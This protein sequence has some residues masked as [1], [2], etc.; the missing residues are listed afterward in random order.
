M[1]T[2]PYF[3]MIYH[4]QNAQH[5]HK[6]KTNH[7]HTHKRLRMADLSAVAATAVVATTKSAAAVNFPATNLLAWRNVECH[8]PDSGSRGKEAT[9]LRGLAGDAQSGDLVAVIGG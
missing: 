1:N 2:I 4:T 8:V 3:M 5:T 9:L 7:A 6:Q